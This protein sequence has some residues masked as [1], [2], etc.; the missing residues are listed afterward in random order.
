MNGDN[1]TTNPFNDAEN[2]VNPIDTNYSNDMDENSS[3]SYN[4]SDLTNFDNVEQSVD[5]INGMDPQD[6]KEIKAPKNNIVKKIPIIIL[7]IILIIVLIVLLKGLMSP[8]EPLDNDQGTQTEETSP[9]NLID[10]RY[11]IEPTNLANGNIMVD[12][13]NKNKISIDAEVAIEF[14]DANGQTVKNETTTIKNIP[15]KSHY[16]STITVAPELRGLQYRV[17]S[18]LSVNKFKD[19]YVD[20]V[21][22]VNKTEEEENLL[23]ELKNDSISTIDTL[24]VYAIFYDENNKVI[25]LE[26]NSVKKV[27][28]DN[29]VSIKVNY[30]KDQEYK[31]ISFSKYEIGINTAYS[32]RKN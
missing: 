1:N 15:P 5:Y 4:T 10:Q 22:V 13:N 25:G 31:S 20:K 8:E 11:S 28:A 27:A 7:I 18:I 16:Y 29:S 14:V 32:Y 6:E 19:Y 9:E 23:V 3:F 17:N 21:V 30:P 26:K 24:E 2:N 12:I